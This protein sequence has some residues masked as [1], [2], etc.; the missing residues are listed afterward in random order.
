MNFE[1]TAETPHPSGTEPT[2]EAPHIPAADSIEQA[3]LR[4]HRTGPG[5]GLN[6]YERPRAN[7]IGRDCTMQLR[8]AIRVLQSHASSAAP[9][10]TT[11]HQSGSVLP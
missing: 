4:G 2:L 6:V 9:T 10:S 3:L 7:A 5:G 8:G 1:Y 11:S